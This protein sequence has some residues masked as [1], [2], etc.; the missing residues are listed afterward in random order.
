[1]PTAFEWSK[2]VFLSNGLV[3][4]WWSEN[5]KKSGFQIVHLIRLS[6]HLKTEQKKCLKSQEFRFQVFCISMVS[7]TQW[8]KTIKNICLGSRISVVCCCKLNN[9]RVCDEH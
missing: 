9:T 4:E 2:S 7:V 5:K 8:G 6:D 3:L 1:M